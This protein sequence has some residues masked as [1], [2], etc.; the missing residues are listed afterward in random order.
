MI[1]LQVDSPVPSP[2]WLYLGMG[3]PRLTP[4]FVSLPY[5][6]RSAPRRLDFL[7]NTGGF[8][9]L[10]L[11]CATGTSPL[12]VCHSLPMKPDGLVG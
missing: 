9:S 3:T 5:A 6:N 7:G 8:D 10:I 11:S 2:H 1:L 4:D 12:A